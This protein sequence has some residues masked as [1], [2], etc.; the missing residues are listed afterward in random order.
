MK[1]LN[2]SFLLEML[3]VL[4]PKLCMSDLLMFEFILWVRRVIMNK[5]T[6]FRSTLTI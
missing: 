1:T 2:L 6:I 3:S 5:E 4:P